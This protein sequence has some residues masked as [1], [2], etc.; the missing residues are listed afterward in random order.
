VLDQ[1]GEEGGPVVQL[2]KENEGS[3]DSDEEARGFPP[4]SKVIEAAKVCGTVALESFFGGLVRH[5]F[6]VE[7]ALEAGLI[8][9]E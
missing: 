4:V 6:G 7:V 9:G 3:G 8:A 5:G 2:G 1:F